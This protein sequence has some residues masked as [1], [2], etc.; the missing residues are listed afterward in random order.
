MV[1]H[2]GFKAAYA[3]HTLYKLQ[4]SKKWFFFIEQY[5]IFTMT[6]NQQQS[7]LYGWGRNQMNPGLILHLL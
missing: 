2:I 7:K 3:A 1:N 6:E 4:K 5:F